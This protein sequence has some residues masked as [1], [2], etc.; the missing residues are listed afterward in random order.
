M[1]MDDGWAS[2]NLFLLLPMRY[3]PCSGRCI[4][5]YLFNSSGWRVFF[6]PSLP[7]RNSHIIREQAI[8]ALGAGI[9]VGARLSR[10]QMDALWLHGFVCV[11][12]VCLCCC[13]GFVDLDLSSV[14]VMDV[15]VVLQLLGCL[16]SACLVLWCLAHVSLPL[17]HY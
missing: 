10:D 14:L 7:L 6:S 17:N 1:S 13:G 3:V 11:R 5:C 2:F 4:P 12:V 9:G 15:F 16:R 8:G